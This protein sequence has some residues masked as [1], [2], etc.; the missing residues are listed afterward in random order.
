MEGEYLVQLNFTMSPELAG[1]NCTLEIIND[2]GSTIYPFTLELQQ[3]R[4]K[5]QNIGEGAAPSGALEA[6]LSNAKA[7]MA[8][9][10]V[11]ALALSSVVF[12]LI[13]AVSIAY[14]NRIQRCAHENCC[15]IGY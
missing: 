11:L 7:S 1:Q 9:G 3:G 15:K 4:R 6:D 12:C 2:L 8:F 5:I 10:S 13:I 14:R